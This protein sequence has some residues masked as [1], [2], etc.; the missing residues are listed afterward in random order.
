[1]GDEAE[2]KFAAYRKGVGNFRKAFGQDAPKTSGYDTSAKGSEIAKVASAESGVEPGVGLY[3]RF[4]E[5]TKGLGKGIMGAGDAFKQWQDNHPAVKWA[6]SPGN[7]VGTF[8]PGA[9][10]AVHA[11]NGVSSSILPGEKPK[12]ANDVAFE[13]SEQ[14]EYS[15]VGPPSAVNGL[16]VSELPSVAKT[17]QASPLAGPQGDTSPFGS[18]KRLQGA[19]LDQLAD[20]SGLQEKKSEEGEAHLQTLGVKAGQFQ[21]LAQAQAIAANAEKTAA[22]E[23]E[24]EQL[25]AEEN[26][27]KASDEASKMGVDPGRFYKNKDAGFWISM[28]VGSV[29]SGMLSGLSSDGKNPFMDSVREMVRAD[30]G[31]Q[32]TGIQQG[33]KKVKGLETAYERARVR[34]TD[35]I[36]ATIRQY[37]STLQALQTDMQGRLLKATIPEQRANIEASLQ[38]LQL[39][40][41]GMRVK[42]EEYWKQV[43]EHRAAAA[44]SAANAAAERQW[45]HAKEMR[46]TPRTTPRLASSLARAREAESS[47]S[48]SSSRAWTKR[49]ASKRVCSPQIRKRESRSRRLYRTMRSSWARSM[50]SQSF[51]RSVAPS[52]AS[53]TSTTR[54]GPPIGNAE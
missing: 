46:R 22:E 31:A 27:H 4:R 20:H 5:S 26:W 9:A 49:T 25:T 21:E 40:R 19:Q 52:V 48:D 54:S 14:P 11:M 2:D 41:D 13:R 44:A 18:D 30:I 24:K 33:W 42:M 37:D 12:S 45:R 50:R 10:L 8:A 51:A 15:R 16:P 34:G 35:R 3:D 43:K 53:T 1:M 17:M 38:A 47:A 39:E 29:A 32:E 23:A 6:L 7:A 36:T 28:I